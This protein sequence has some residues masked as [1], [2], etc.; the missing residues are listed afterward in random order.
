MKSQ[1]SIAEDDQASESSAGGGSG[2]EENDVAV[3]ADRHRFETRLAK[4]HE[5]PEAVIT[6]AETETIVLLDIRSLVPGTDPVD[7]A[8]VRENNRRYL[9]VRILYTLTQVNNIR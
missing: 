7:E 2:D 9:E 6:L 5:N 8:L 4:K 1:G 3:R